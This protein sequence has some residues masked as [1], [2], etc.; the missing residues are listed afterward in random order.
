MND[1]SPP[2]DDQPLIRLEA[3]SRSFGAVRAVDA[4]SFD[5]CRGEVHG[6]CGHNGAGKSTVVKMLFG[7]LR[8]DSGQISIEGENVVL[9]SPQEA[10]AHGNAL[11]DQ[12]LSVVPSLSVMDN[13]LLGGVH[14][15]Q[16]RR[17]RDA[18][19]L[20]RSL[21]DSVGLDDIEPSD[22]VEDLPIGHRQ[23]VEI[24]RA[25]GREARLLI[26]DEPTATLSGGE[27]EHVFA[28]VRR[29][30]AD[31]RA[32]IY[33]SHRLDEVMELCE[34]V[35]VLRNG[36]CVATAPCRE[37]TIPSLVE[38]MLGEPPAAVVR[39]GN[40]GGVTRE[41]L[42]V[43]HLDVGATTRDFELSADGGTIYGLAGQIGSGSG[44]VLRAIAGL[45]PDARGSVRIFGAGLSLGTP[46]RAARAGVAYLSN[47]RK[48]EGLFLGQSVG[49]NLVATRLSSLSR[50]GVVRTGEARA[51]AKNL[52]E[53]I[54]IP[55]DRLG[56]PVMRLSGGNQQKVLLERCLERDD[57]R[58]LLLDDPTRGVDV[59]GRA[60]IH[61][62]IRG[63]AQNGTVV[64]FASTE[65]EEILSLADVIVTMRGGR[66][67]SRRG[68]DQAHARDILADMT[69]TDVRRVG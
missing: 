63:A 11:V 51:V 14:E 67:V 44:D 1:D 33:V 4:V 50:F 43:S 56:E 6:L 19:K 69:H 58:V 34:R 59:R 39:K 26:L 46:G 3:V 41:A 47:D 28:A 62:L 12:E 16:F 31:G 42:V 35:T 29:V 7:L 32:V 27:I 60:E 24:A 13:V 65:L 2:G 18:V 64:L 36:K 40:R 48:G 15:P 57:T 61:E 49:S 17:R 53:T 23:L 5:V 20:V 9:N 30:V 21:L 66:I 38:M 8:P 22:Y 54:G 45:A 55:P 68:R 25:L 52:G 10:Q 37:L